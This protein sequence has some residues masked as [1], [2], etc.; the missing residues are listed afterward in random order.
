VVKVLEAEGIKPEDCDTRYA[1]VYVDCKDFEQAHRIA[2]GGIWR[3]MSSAFRSNIEP[4][5][6]CVEIG[7]AYLGGALVQALERKTS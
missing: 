2:Q 7:L 3:V 6:P 1:D 4:H 5:P